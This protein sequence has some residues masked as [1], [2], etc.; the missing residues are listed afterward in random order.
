MPDGDPCDAV[1]LWV[2]TQTSNDTPIWARR[3]LCTAASAVVLQSPR[4]PA[5]LPPAYTTLQ[6]PLY[7]TR[8]TLSPPGLMVTST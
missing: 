5:L 7:V 4:W 2:G 6:Q 1:C 8:Y 3:Q